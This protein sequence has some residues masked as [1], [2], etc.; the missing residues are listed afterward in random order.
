MKCQISKSA[1]EVLEKLS[2]AST[3][4]KVCSA[5]NL[6]LFSKSCLNHKTEELAGKFKESANTKIENPG[7]FCNLSSW[8]GLIEDPKTPYYP[9]DFGVLRSKMSR[10]F[11]PSSQ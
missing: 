7:P 6:F 4:D 2:I 9:H 5:A 11:N 3:K 8:D 1:A 10:K